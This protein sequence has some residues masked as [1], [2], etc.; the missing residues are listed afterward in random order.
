MTGAIELSVIHLS[1][2]NQYGKYIYGKTSLNS[3]WRVDLHK[4]LRMINPQERT[5]FSFDF[6]S[7]FSTTSF[8]FFWCLSRCSF[9]SGE[10][11]ASIMTYKINAFVR[12]KLFVVKEFEN[13]AS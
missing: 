1:G 3:G 10:A 2:R 13:A 6:D 4:S 8:I 12:E 7:Y 11:I 9:H 5:L